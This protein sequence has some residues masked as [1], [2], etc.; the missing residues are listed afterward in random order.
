MHL[1]R[2]MNFLLLKISVWWMEGKECSLPIPRRATAKEE[3]QSIPTS[4]F[5]PPTPQKRNW[6]NPNFGL[7]NATQVLIYEIVTGLRNPSTFV[8]NESNGYT[9]GSVLYDAFKDQILYAGYSNYTARLT[10]TCTLNADATT[11]YGANGNRNEVILTWSRTSGDHYDTLIDDTHT[12]T[13]GLNITKL[14]S[15]T[16][17]ETAAENGMFQ[18]VKFKIYNDND[19]QWIKAALNE[20][21]GIYYVN[22]HTK[23]EAEATVFVPVTVGDKRGQI[24]LSGCEDDVLRITELETANGYTL[25]KDDIYVEITVAEDEGRPCN[26]YSKD[27]LGVLQN[28]PHY[29]FD[30]GLDLELS[31]IPQTQLAHNHL[32]ATAKVDGNAINMQADNGSLNAAATLTIMN[33]AGFDL[34]QTGDSGVALY[35]LIGILLMAGA[36]FVLVLTFRKKKN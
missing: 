22:G 18:H 15:D 4:S 17:S 23:D 16:D 21:T 26:I 35:G 32:T 29:S 25:L 1:W 3:K 14:F 9:N 7:R 6:K 2:W 31:N 10:Y 24:V 20:D 27:I 13:F 33:T 11:V 19:G 12:Y 8:R 5:P 34:P 28:D 30:G 36:A